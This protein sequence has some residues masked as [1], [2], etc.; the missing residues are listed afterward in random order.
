VCVCVCVNSPTLY[1]QHN[2]PLPLPTTQYPP[3]DTHSIPHCFVSVEEL[4]V[5][6]VELKRHQLAWREAEVTQVLQWLEAGMCVYM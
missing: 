1:T 5:V 2:N 4:A 3:Q 6:A